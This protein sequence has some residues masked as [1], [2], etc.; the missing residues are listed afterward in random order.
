M[1]L[2]GLVVREAVLLLEGLD[3]RIGV[4][5]VAF[6]LVPADVEIRIGEEPGHL[7]EEGVEERIDLL[8]GRIEGRG[9]DAELALDRVGA[10]CARESGIGDEPA[11]RMARQ[12]ELGHD[13]DA[14]VGG[15]FDDLLDLD[16]GEEHPVR[17][18]L[19]ELGE[20][21]RFDAEALVLGQVEVQDVHLDR[22]HAV[23]VA[24]DDVD[25]LEMA[26]DV[27]HQAAPGET[28][29]VDDDDGGEIIAFFV[30]AQQ[31]E[32]GLEAPQNADVGLGVQDD[33]GR[34]D[35]EQVGLV[36]GG[37]YLAGTGVRISDAALTGRCLRRQEVLLQEKAGPAG[38]AGHEA[39]GGFECPARPELRA[40]RSPGSR[41][42]G[43][44]LR[45]G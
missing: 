30:R 35:R 45:R 8:V 41:R 24:L 18:E 22:G 3:G 13:P 12:V 4:P 32:E 36:L 38:Q 1:G 14:A 21:L 25:G 5:L 6:D 31:L 23:D 16:L 9:E 39:S 29:L 15:V 20:D 33:P 7:L 28:G 27:D 40:L 17:A 19:V 43:S 11:G 34:L 26:A 37:Q 10:G 42:S 44:A 2:Q